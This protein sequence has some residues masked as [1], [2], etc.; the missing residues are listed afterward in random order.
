MAK[1]IA[2]DTSTEACSVAL[3]CDGARIERFE[4]L[5]R[6]HAERILVMVSEVLAEAGLALTDLDALGFCRGPGSFTGVRIGTGVAQGLAFGADLPVAPVSTL[7]ALAQGAWRAH[8]A[9]H[10]LAAIDAR[11]GEVYW[12]VYGREG[13]LMQALGVEVVAPAAAVE[14]PAHGQWYGVGTGWAT[15][16]EALGERCG[17]KL[18]GHDPQALPRAL[19]CLPFVAQAWQR[20]ELVA[21]EE[22]LPVYL[23]DRVTG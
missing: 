21:A 5:P 9:E 18:A 11:M 17:A 1:F 3:A 6:G 19:D 23:R 4:L 13:E 2:V 7:G 16:A 15:Y 12:G 20:G 14:L 22:A 10:V 8:G